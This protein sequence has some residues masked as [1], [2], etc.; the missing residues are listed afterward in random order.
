MSLV[1][2]VLSRGSPGHTRMAPATSLVTRL[3][4][5]GIPGWLAWSCILKRKVYIS[6]VDD[7]Q[8]IGRVC[9]GNQRDAHCP[10]V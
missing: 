2:R 1:W 8:G 4:G 5:G 7:D 10:E 6:V 3:V 9:G